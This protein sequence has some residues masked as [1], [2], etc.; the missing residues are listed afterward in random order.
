M[1]EV[2]EKVFSKIGI[3]E[4]EFQQSIDFHMNSTENVKYV[5]CMT[6]ETL[7]D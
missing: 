4:K 5:R 1:E 2:I 6:D 3:T 7:I